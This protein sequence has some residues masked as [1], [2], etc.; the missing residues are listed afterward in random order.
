M[1]RYPMSHMKKLSLVI[2]FLILS[3]GIVLGALIYVISTHNP[4]EGEYSGTFVNE[5]LVWTYT[6]NL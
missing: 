4:G 3:I 2:L 6:L 5:V 1:V